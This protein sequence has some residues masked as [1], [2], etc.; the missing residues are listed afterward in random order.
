MMFS[1]WRFGFPITVIIG[2]M[3]LS[4]LGFIMAHLA[5]KL[6]L[7]SHPHFLIT[8]DRGYAE[9]FQYL[10]IFW[11]IC[12]LALLFMRHKAAVLLAWMFIFGYMLLDDSL[13]VHE[14]GGSYLVAN[15]DIQP[16]LRLRAQDFGELLVTAIAGT[17]LFS[18]LAVTYFKAGAY[19]RRVTHRLLALVAAIAFFGIVIDMVHIMVPW[20]NTFFAILEDGGEM[21]IMSLTL[22]YCFHLLLQTHYGTNKAAFTAA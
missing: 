16:A 15:L 12:L 3:V 17:F 13:K 2:L 18:F 4:D 7:V 11:V 9:V 8:R 5:F 19:A 21:L 1:Q 10:K 22:G 14:A 6:D 20:G